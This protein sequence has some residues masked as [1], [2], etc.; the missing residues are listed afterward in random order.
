M[1]KSLLIIAFL[2]GCICGDAAGQQAEKTPDSSGVISLEGYQPLDLTT[3]E[4]VFSTLGIE[5][6]PKA[7]QYYFR[8]SGET[9]YTKVSYF[10]VN[11]TPY[12]Q[13]VPEARSTMNS[14]LLLRMAHVVMFY[15]GIATAAGGA[16]MSVSN[17]ELSPVLL[18]GAAL[19]SVSWI[20]L[21]FSHD[22]VPD[23][24][25]IYNEKLS[26]FEKRDRE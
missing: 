14:F 22:N 5:K 17:K 25:G 7:N 3:E 23:A 24:I 21:F 13:V 26:E 16:A 19:F 10:G 15:G 8:V 9:E 11:L 18:L 20:P 1:N 4:G 12:I 2:V 6:K